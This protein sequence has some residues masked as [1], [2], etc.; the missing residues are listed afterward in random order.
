MNNDTTNRIPFIWASTD[1]M[2]VTIA[3]G[4]SMTYTTD[5]TNE[6][7]NGCILSLTQ[8]TTWD[9]LNNYSVWPKGVS[10]ESFEKK[11]TPKWHI[12]LG[13]KNQMNTMWD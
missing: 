5:N 2:G 9:Y 3:A 4:D 13:Y 10:D 8:N 6:N 12:I 1:S 7:Y 11:Y